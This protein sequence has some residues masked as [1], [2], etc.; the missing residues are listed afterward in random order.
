[1]QCDV[2]HLDAHCLDGY[3]TQIAI[4]QK[5]LLMFNVHAYLILFLVSYM[6][7]LVGITYILPTVLFQLVCYAHVFPCTCIY[8][9]T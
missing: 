2:H 1:M 4:D 3:V 9:H 6:F 7:V 8:M 5:A